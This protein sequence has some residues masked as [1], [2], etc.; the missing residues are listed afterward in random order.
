MR[1]HLTVEEASRAIGF[2][3]TGLSQRQV[4]AQFNV[5]HTVIGRLWTRYQQTNSVQR[6]PKSG[7]PKSMTAHQDRR[8]ALLAKRYRM[9]SAVT[10]NRVSCSI[11]SWISTQTVRNR[12]HAS[13]LHAR[14]P[15]VRPPLTARHR[16]CRLQFARRHANWGVRRIRP[17]L[18]TDESRFCLDFHDGR[19]RVWR[20]KNERFK[21]CCVAEHD[22]FGGGSVMAWGGISYDGSTDLYVIRNGSLTGIRYR[23]EIL[24]PIVRL[25][26]GANDD[27]FILMDD[28]ATPHRARIVNEYLQ[29]ETIERMDW[30]A[31]SPDLN[32]IEHAW[33]ILQCRISNRQN[34]P[35]SLQ[36][37]A[38]ALVD[39]W[40]RI[41]QVEF[42]RLIRS[43]QNRCR[44][45][46][47]ARGGH[48]RY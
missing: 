43:F 42:Q 12:L 18:F 40:S 8:I 34:Q 38:D 45:V 20:Q 41:P 39:E 15:A 10:L 3:Q 48:N 5:S 14:K 32:P 46:I 31:K 4:G 29:Q 33:D 9:S 28:N 44:E 47:R 19:R 37:L 24:A 22:R 30:P 21:N 17:I 26:A 13:G 36:E 16:N 2:L 11:R 1:R 27:D 7:R 23:D 25:Y 35:N 6:R